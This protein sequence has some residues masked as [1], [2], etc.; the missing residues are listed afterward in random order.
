MEGNKMKYISIICCFILGTFLIGCVRIEEN[1]VLTA[2]IVDINDNSLSV[3]TSDEGVDFT[4]ASVDITNVKDIAFNL[5]IGQTVELSILPEI[6]ES[7]PVQVTAVSLGLQQAIYTKISPEEA[8]EIMSDEVVILDVRTESE[9]NDGHIEGS[10][11]IP[12][13]D[14]KEL[15]PEILTD[16]NATILVYCRSGARSKVASELLIEMGYQN[17]MDFGGIIDWPYDIVTP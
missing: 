13:T 5:I 8:K 17:I 16:T 10:V 12:D 2:L 14:I 11:L 15:A 1:I 4:E 6:M 3:T 7:Y 9:Y